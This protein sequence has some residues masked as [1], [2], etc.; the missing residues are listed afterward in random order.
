MQYLNKPHAQ[1]I[2]LHYS[3]VTKDLTAQVLNICRSYADCYAATTS[4]IL[5]MS[6]SRYIVL[7]RI[8]LEINCNELYDD[9]PVISHENFFI[10]SQ[11][12]VT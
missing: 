5:H 10:E 2:H 6:D 9:L 8:S 3:L 1:F 4:V 11:V 7:V 12:Y